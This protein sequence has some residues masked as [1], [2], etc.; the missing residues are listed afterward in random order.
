MQISYYDREPLQKRT[1]TATRNEYLIHSLVVVVLVVVSSSSS[2]SPLSMYP[3][4]RCGNA[5]LYSRLLFEKYTL[6]PPP[7][8]YIIQFIKFSFDGLTKFIC[9]TKRNK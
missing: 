4:T 9:Q 2:S 3:Y 1:K 7:L 6:I 5:F 8:I